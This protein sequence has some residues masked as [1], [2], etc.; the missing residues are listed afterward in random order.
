MYDENTKNIIVDGNEGYKKAQ[1]FMKMMMP[2][3][4]KKVKKYRGKLP[5]FIEENIEQKL[6][7][8][9]DTEIKLTSG[10]Y[11]V[12]NPTEALVSIDINSGSSIKQKLSLIHI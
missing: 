3:N 4:V 11:L 10:G 6:N 2:S 8:I 1:S 7:Q 9:F 5:L 12:I